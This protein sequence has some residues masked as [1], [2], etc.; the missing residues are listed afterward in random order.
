MTKLRGFLCW[1]FGALALVHL[2]AVPIVFRPLSHGRRLPTTTREIIG[3]VLAELLLACPAMI[4]LTSGMAWWTLT[5]GKASGRRWAIT[6]SSVFLLPALLGT[7]AELSLWKY[8]H[9][10]VFFV[11]VILVIPSL[12]IAITGLVAF[13]PRNALAQMPVR[14]A[15]PPR[16]AGDGTSGA[17]DVLAIV[18]QIASVI[19]MVRW[20]DH[21]SEVQ[22]LPPIR[23]GLLQIGLA[24]LLLTLLHE[25]GHVA[26]GIAVGIKLW[27]FIVGPFQWRI[28]DGRWRFQFVLSK[29]FVGGGAAALAPTDPRQSH[30]KDV[31]VTAAG[32]LANLC[33]G[34]VAIYLALL[35]DT[36]PQARNFLAIFSTFSLV[37]FAGNLIPFRRELY[38]DGARIFQILSAGPLADYHRLV[39]V[40][41]STLVTPTRARDFDIEAIR[42]T[43]LVVTA[44]TQG[45]G[46]RL[47]AYAYYLDRGEL[48]EASAALIDAQTAFE[49]CT[50]AYSAAVYTI[51]VFGNAYVRRDAAAAREW[52]ERMRSK[53]P[54]FNV[55]YWL[56]KCALHWIE[57]N[58]E[59]ANAAWTK[60]N[61]KAQ[62]LPRFGAY[63]SDRYHCCLLRD[64]LG[65][66]ANAAG[67]AAGGA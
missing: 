45:F 20:W 16:I 48:G 27:H 31:W 25:C 62:R 58:F 41:A 63:E 37:A 52:W 15:K 42:R 57:N 67:A 29:M 1:C 50:S 24:G 36:N 39:S 32:P 14:A 64:A 33:T 2:F 34:S 60:A 59:Q 7:A 21:W 35:P 47:L 56:A 65:T 66:G 55:D 40:S 38:S 46:L 49:P 30:W 6:A 8:G 10:A 18:L 43:A 5:R 26:A 19:A 17:V 44:G 3:F 28:C 53:K 61:E 23:W 9:Q 11:L 54:E 4:T 22:E 51:F 13:V 12:L